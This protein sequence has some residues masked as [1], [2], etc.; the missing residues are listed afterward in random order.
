M[1]FNLNLILL[2]VVIFCFFLGLDFD[3]FEMVGFIFIMGDSVV[4]G[5]FVVIR[6]RSDSVFLSFMLLVKSLLC[7]GIGCL[8]VR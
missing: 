4:F 3:V 8:L 2:V 1:I 7:K 5:W 6:V